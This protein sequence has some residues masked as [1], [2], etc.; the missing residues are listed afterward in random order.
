ME[1]TTTWGLKFNFE[2]QTFTTENVASF[3]FRL[4]V[5][6]AEILTEHVGALN[7]RSRGQG[8]KRQQLNIIANVKAHLQCIVCVCAMCWSV[9]LVCHCNAKCLF[10][11]SKRK[12]KKK[13][14][15]FHC[16][17]MFPSL[18]S[19][20]STHFPRTINIITACRRA[21]TH[22]KISR[23]ENC[24]LSCGMIGPVSVSF[25]CLVWQ[26]VFRFGQKLRQGRLR[27][28]QAHKLVMHL[29]Y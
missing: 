12:R 28:S 22:P 23:M 8:Q 5:K 10:R 9:V 6:F 15:E 25:G 13:F 7:S 1:T 20:N 26:C 27:I 21:D 24:T 17:S 3:R 19:N 14:T 18:S 16:V 11:K 29:N 2:A 4:N